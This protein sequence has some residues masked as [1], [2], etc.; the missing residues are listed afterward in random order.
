[1]EF[2]MCADAC[3]IDYAALLDLHPAPHWTGDHKGTVA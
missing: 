1:M 2:V 3:K